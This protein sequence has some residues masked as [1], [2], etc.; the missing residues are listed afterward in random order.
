MS[1]PWYA[2]HPEFVAEWDIYR[3]ANG[4]PVVLDFDCQYMAAE[5]LPRALTADELVAVRRAVYVHGLV[6]TAENSDQHTLRPGGEFDWRSPNAQKSRLLGRMIH[7]GKP[8]TR[9]RPPVEAAEPR[10]DLMPGGDPFEPKSAVIVSNDT[11]LDLDAIHRVLATVMSAPEA[12][13]GTMASTRLLLK[14][15]PLLVGEV[16]RLREHVRRIEHMEILD[17]HEVCDTQLR[18][19]RA[20]VARYRN[21]LTEAER[22][23]DQVWDSSLRGEQRWPA[24]DE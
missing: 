5:T 6:C 17:D 19:A 13:R 24:T 16:E 21:A 8:P 1:S 11:P 10:W 2:D 14:E 22:R 4:T 7:D 18:A 23:L 20:E 9:T 12:R 3:D 15:V